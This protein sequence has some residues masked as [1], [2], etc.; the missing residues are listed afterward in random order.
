MYNKYN[1]KNSFESYIMFGILIEFINFYYSFVLDYIESH[2]E[3]KQV[4][5]VMY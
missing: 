1:K 2:I 4:V 5:D 3:R